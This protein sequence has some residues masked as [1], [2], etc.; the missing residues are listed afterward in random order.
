MA[1]HPTEKERF[2]ILL[3]ELRSQF[4]AV[5]EYVLSLNKK[6]DDL[7]TELKQEL[8]EFKIEVR[9]GFASINSQLPLMQQILFDHEHRIKRLE[10]TPG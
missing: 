5:T 9:A 4:K 6:I 8:H 2:T 10:G 7:R 1:K 3:E